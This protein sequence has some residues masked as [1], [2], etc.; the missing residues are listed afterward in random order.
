MPTLQ[1]FSQ[2]KSIGLKDSRDD[3]MSCQCPGDQSQHRYCTFKFTNTHQKIHSYT[4]TVLPTCV[5][6]AKWQRK[7]HRQ[8]MATQ[9]YILYEVKLQLL[10]FNANKVSKS[11]K[12]CTLHYLSD[13]VT[14]T[15]NTSACNFHQWS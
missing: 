13:H 15:L 12:L 3:T 6:R 9:S 11:V 5:C 7:Y 4:G 1:Q 2:N 14:M 10:I 8:M